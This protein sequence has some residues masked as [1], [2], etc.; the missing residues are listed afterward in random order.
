MVSVHTLVEV[1]DFTFVAVRSLVF[2]DGVLGFVGFVDVALLVADDDELTFWA[3]KLTGMLT[4]DVIVRL[5]DPD[6]LDVLSLLVARVKCC[7][8]SLAKRV[9]VELS[10]S[11]FVLEHFDPV[12]EINLVLDGAPSEMVREGLLPESDTVELVVPVSERFKSDVVSEA[13]VLLCVREGPTKNDQDLVIPMLPDVVVVPIRSELVA[14]VPMCEYVADSTV[15]V[16]LKVLEN[17][18][19]NVNGATEMDRVLV[20]ETEIVFSDGSCEVDARSDGDSIVQLSSTEAVFDA[21]NSSED[22]FVIEP[23]R[24]GEKTLVRVA[25]NVTVVVSSTVLVRCVIE[26]VTRIVDEARE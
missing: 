8:K 1:V 22:V 3:V 17:V 2:L 7:V 9:E 6:P 13:L 5:M 20:E 10:V 23:S 4:V 21:D 26:S 14:A 15:F 24:L 12:T 16:S 19:D 11:S 18:M 25:R